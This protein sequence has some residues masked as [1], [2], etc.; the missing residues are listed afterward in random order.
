MNLLRRCGLLVAAW[1]FLLA[2]C[3][4]SLLP[5]PQ[6]GKPLPSVTLAGPD[7][8]WLYA[9]HGD[10]LYRRKVQATG[11]WMMGAGR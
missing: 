11:A 1:P 4:G 2:G 5:K 10:T 7:R 6:P 9:A 3:S 8:S